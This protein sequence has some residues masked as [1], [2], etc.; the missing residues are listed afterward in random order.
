MGINWPAL[1]TL[2]RIPCTGCLL[3]AQMTKLLCIK[4]WGRSQLQSG[5]SAHMNWYNQ[6]MLKQEGRS[7]MWPLPLLNR[8]ETNRCATPMPQ[9]REE[10]SSSNEPGLPPPAKLLVSA[11]IRFCHFGYAQSPDSS[12]LQLPPEAKRYKKSL[13]RAIAQSR[14]PK[15]TVD[16]K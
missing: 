15:R 2:P 6:I 3:A 5:M 4:C 1:S 7:E 11:V 14:G 13:W 9:C 16:R 8:G 12:Q 10:P